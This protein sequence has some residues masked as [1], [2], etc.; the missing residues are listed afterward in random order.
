MMLLYKAKRLRFLYTHTFIHPYIY[1]IYIEYWKSFIG[2]SGKCTIPVEHQ[3]AHVFG[4]FI[5]EG[6]IE[7]HHDGRIKSQ[8]EYNPVPNGLGNAMY[9]LYCEVKSSTRSVFD[10]IIS[11]LGKRR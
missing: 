10:F 6:D 4:S 8:T 9:H 7:G 3:K 1:E 2:V 11:F 5:F